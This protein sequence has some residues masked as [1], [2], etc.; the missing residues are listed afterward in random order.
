MGW[1]D[2]KVTKAPILCW[3]YD[4]LWTSVAQGRWH[5]A[6]ACVK[7]VWLPLG[8][9]W[10]H[11]VIIKY[12]AYCVVVLLY[13]LEALGVIV[14]I[15]MCASGTVRWYEQSDLDTADC[16]NLQF[17]NACCKLTSFT[18]PFLRESHVYRVMSCLDSR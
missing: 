10:F 3:P 16:V 11:E 1:E 12:F 14:Y 15:V 17:T 2:I 13:Q 8:K 9:A 7:S 5:P 18:A 6:C 4:A